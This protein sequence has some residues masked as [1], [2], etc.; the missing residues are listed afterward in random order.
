MLFQGGGPF[1]HVCT[2]GAEADIYFRNEEE[3]NLALNVIALAVFVTGCRLLAFAVMSNHFH[4]LIEGSIDECVAFFEEFKS[5]LCK[6]L[7]SASA[8]EEARKCVVSYIRVE[9]LAQLRTE[10]AYVVRNPFV[11]NR[12]VNMFSYPWCS[13]YLYF[14]G[15]ESRMKEGER[16][17]D[18]PH[19][20]R[21]AFLHS[22]SADIDPRITVLDG[23]AMPSCFVD[24]HRAESFF[25]DARDFQH[26]LLKN[27]ESQVVIAK[28]IGESVSLDD[29][30]LRSIMFQ[31]CNTVYHVSGPKE[32]NNQDFVNLA[33]T[34]KYDFCASN[35]QLSR[36]LNKPQ[37]QIDQIFPLSAR[38]T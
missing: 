29:Y 21:R 10:I 16:A 18:M 17:I 23:V 38:K 2:K 25:E 3:M 8:R 28:R 33:R 37:S 34:L 35:A 26:C 15:N 13:G 11:A 7:P 9:D 12:N 1:Y 14:N 22:R 32:L 24:Y 36:I 5:R 27:V 20:F 31:K 19:A 4:F 6:V 30:E